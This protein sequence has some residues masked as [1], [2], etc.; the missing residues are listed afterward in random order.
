[1]WPWLAPSPTFPLAAILQGQAGSS[2]GPKVTRSPLVDSALSLAD[3]VSML[4]A[5][6]FQSAELRKMTKELRA[7]Y[8]MCGSFI[9]F[10]AVC[11]I[12]STY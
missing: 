6:T 2:G 5:V 1:M 12:V 9:A 8:W 7:D 4:K 11:I 10:I 3:C